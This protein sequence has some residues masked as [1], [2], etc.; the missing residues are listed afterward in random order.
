MNEQWMA[1]AAEVRELKRRNAELEARCARQADLI[2][3]EHALFKNAMAAAEALL[4]ER[5]QYKAMCELHDAQ[6]ERKKA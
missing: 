5:N 4:A 3:R 1:L 2:D 6:H